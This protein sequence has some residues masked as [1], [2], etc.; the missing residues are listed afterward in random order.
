MILTSF[1]VL[2]IVG[3]PAAQ[4]FPGLFAT[5]NY[6]FGTNVL[7]IDD[8]NNR[9]GIG[10][11]SPR[12]LLHLKQSGGDVIAEYEINDDDVRILMN[13]I[14]HTPDIIWYYGILN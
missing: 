14:Q 9:V 2:G 13:A 7:F 3:H 4:V 5:G 10:T 11:D 8:T 12:E 6:T 1:S